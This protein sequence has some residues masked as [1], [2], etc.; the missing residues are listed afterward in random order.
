MNAVFQTQ[1]PMVFYDQSIDEG[2]TYSK[3]N[4]VPKLRF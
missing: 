1:Q 2:S 3:K 4:I